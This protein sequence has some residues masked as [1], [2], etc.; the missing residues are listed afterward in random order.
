MLLGEAQAASMVTPTAVNRLDMIPA[1]VNLAG[2]EIELPRMER[3]LHRLK[4][5]LAPLRDSGAYDYIFL[6]CPPSLGNLTMNAMTAA[7]GLIIPMQT[8]YY[9]LEGL[10]VMLRLLKQ[11]QESGANPELEIDGVVLTMYDARTN[12]AQQVVQQVQAHLGDKVFQTVIPRTVSEAPS[13]GKPITL[14]DKHC[15]GAAAYRQLAKEFL[16]RYRPV[17]PAA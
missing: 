11:L 8:E 7:Q 6:D 1:E 12:L 16:Q 4:E 5:A 9:A 2:A 14:Y 3:Y 15:S 13:Y 10:S 17:E